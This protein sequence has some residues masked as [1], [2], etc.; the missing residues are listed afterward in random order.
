MSIRSRVDRLEEAQLDPHDLPIQVVVRVPTGDG[1]TEAAAV[2]IAGTDLGTI[3]RED[4]ESEGAFLRRV[5]TLR[6]GDD[7]FANDIEAAQA[8]TN[9]DL[10]RRYVA[11]GTLGDAYW[12]ELFDRV[13]REGRRV[14]AR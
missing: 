8:S 1:G 5:C 6:A 13:A 11:E 4:T 2:V 12:R 10:A 7:M 14:G 9:D 3:S